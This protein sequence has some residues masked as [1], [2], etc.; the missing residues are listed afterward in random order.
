[1]TTVLLTTIAVGNAGIEGTVA[2]RIEIELLEA[3]Y[4]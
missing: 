3:L 2:H 1:M 4:P